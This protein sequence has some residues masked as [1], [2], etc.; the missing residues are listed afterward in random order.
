[1]RTD[2][3]ERALE[4]HIE[5]LGQA[6]AMDRGDVRRRAAEEYDTERIA[7]RVVGALWETRTPRVSPVSPTQPRL[8]DL[9]C[10]DTCLVAGNHLSGLLPLSR[11]VVS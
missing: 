3:D 6:Q 7:D 5:S 10:S 2:E 8:R 9:A 4:V 11:R 1:M